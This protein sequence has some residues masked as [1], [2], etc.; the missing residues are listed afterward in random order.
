MTRLTAVTVMAIAVTIP[1]MPLPPRRSHPTGRIVASSSLRI[2]SDASTSATVL[3]AIPSNATV[4]IQCT[5]PAS[6]L[7]RT[8][9]K[10]PARNARARLDSRE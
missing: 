6:A 7:P 8:G 3:G 4:G 1:G 5:K 9:D 2:R 10:R